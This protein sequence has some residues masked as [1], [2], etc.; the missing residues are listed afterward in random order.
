MRYE[1]P[2]FIDVEDKLF[3]PLTFKQFI[4]L[5]GGGS[6]CYI[7]Y[8]FLPFTIAMLFIIP[9][10]LLS[11]ALAFYKL[12]TRPFIEVLQNFVTYI[13]RPK[14][15]LWKRVEQKQLQTVSTKIPE[16]NPQILYEPINLDRRITDLSKNLDLLD[17]DQ[18]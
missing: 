7:C 3:G 13:L 17:R 6:I 16:V 4:Y 9:V 11:A 10:G 8:N 12:N 1:L 2:Q 14:S 18:F 5:L 15:Y